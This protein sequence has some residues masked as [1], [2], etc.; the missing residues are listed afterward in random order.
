MEAK[1]KLTFQFEILF[2]L[3]TALVVVGFIYP[4]YKTGALFPFYLMLI[5]F[6]ITFVTLTRY[7]FLLKFTA[8]SHNMWVK[9]IL[10]VCSIPFVFFL[11]SQLNTFQTFIDEEG[12]DQFFR[13]MPLVERLDLQKYI[14]S[15]MIFFGTGAIIASIIFPFRMMISIWRNINKQT[16]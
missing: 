1:Q 12:L 10:I 5:I 4:I 9:G 16:A 6:I 8:I 2:W 13:F 15:V 3:F 7:I 14:R 11:I